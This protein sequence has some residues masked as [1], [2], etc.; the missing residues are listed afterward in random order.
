MVRS[1]FDLLVDTMIGFYIEGFTTSVR[2]RVTIAPK[3][4]FFDLGIKRALDFSLGESVSESTYGY[5]KL[6]E[7]LV[8][9]ELYRINSYCRRNYQF[10]YIRTQSGVEV[11]LVL[12]LGRRELI[13]VEI[14][15]T[16]AVRDDHLRSL[17]SLGKELSATKRYCLSNDPSPRIEDG[18]RIVP[19][20]MGIE[21]IMMRK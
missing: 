10:S 8:L 16:D 18:V 3:F 15:S 13:L 14:K 21:E 17:L 4:Y 5:G 7:T 1:Y 9:Q 20:R 6:F 2:K 19:W 12:R 11:D